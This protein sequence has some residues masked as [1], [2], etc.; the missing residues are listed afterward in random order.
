[1]LGEMGFLWFLLFHSCV[2]RF[3]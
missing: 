1:M 2:E 3:K